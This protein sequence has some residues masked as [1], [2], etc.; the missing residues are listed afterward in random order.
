MSSHL[1]VLILFQN[2]GSHPCFRFV[3]INCLHAVLYPDGASALLWR[4]GLSTPMIPRAVPV[5]GSF[6]LLAVQPCRSG[7][8]GRG[9]TKL[10]S[11]SSRLETR[12]TGEGSDETGTFYKVQQQECVTPSTSRDTCTT[13]IHSQLIIQNLYNIMKDSSDSGD[14]TSGDYS[15][16]DSDGDLEEEGQV[17]FFFFH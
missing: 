15:S 17:F 12:F 7:L 2:G 5:S 13:S 1:Y 14:S 9:Q 10:A 8:Q 11:Q 6:V 16:I 4:G 3:F